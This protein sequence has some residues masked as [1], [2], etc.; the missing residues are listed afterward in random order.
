MHSAAACAGHIEDI[1]DF[2]AIVD[3]LER[4]IRG[5]MSPGGHSAGVLFCDSDILLPEFAGE[6]AGRFDFPIIGASALAH[7]S[8]GGPLSDTAQLLAMGGDGCAFSAA[9]TE[10][11]DA[12]EYEGQI[13]KAFAE[14]EAGLAGAEP[15]LVFLFSPFIVNKNMPRDFAAVLGEVSGALPVVGGIA[16]DYMEFEKVKV[17]FGGKIYDDRLA[18]LV[19]GGD[20]RPVFAVCDPDFA[21]GKF[22]RVTETDGNILKRLDGKGTFLDYCSLLGMSGDVAVNASFHV[23]RGR[24]VENGRPCDVIRTV[25]RVFPDTGFAE[26]SAELPVGEEI[27]LC[28][29]SLKGVFDSCSEGMGRLVAAMRENEADGYKYSCVFAF[30]CV[31]RRI[32]IGLSSRENEIIL[33]ALPEGVDLSGFYTLGEFGPVEFEGGLAGGLLFNCALVFCAL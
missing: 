9:L 27:S 5:K 19:A 7:L 30:S 28:A 15:K 18:I 32:I 23:I 16:S 11:L 12:G 33:G 21:V 6:L 3:G 22:A 2:K 25:R 1:S 26:V 8:P 29:I 4:E 20:I 14:A 31:L 10:P 17:V 24:Y 13:A